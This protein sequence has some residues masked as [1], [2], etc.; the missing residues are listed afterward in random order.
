MSHRPGVQ[1]G[2]RVGRRTLA[3]RG[4]LVIAMRAAGEPWPA[5]A[6]AVGRSERMC[7]RYAAWLRKAS[8]RLAMSANAGVPPERCHFRARDLPFLPMP[9]SRREREQ[10]A[11]LTTHSEPS[12]PVVLP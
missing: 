10:R 2:V 5:V 11:V 7:R 4:Y 1:V 9:D 6:A 8:P 3:E 12:G